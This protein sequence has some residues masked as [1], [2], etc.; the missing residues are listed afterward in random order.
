MPFFWYKYSMNYK[1]DKLNELLR[2][3]IA[4]AILELYPDQFL[5]VVRVETT[6]DIEH[7]KAWVDTHNESVVAEL[8]INEK[9]IKKLIIPNLKI[10]RVPKIRFILDTTTTDLQN[11]ENLLKKIKK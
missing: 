10:R 1:I 5:S 11:I 6:K 4:K 8:N 3:N 7:C 9:T 2:V